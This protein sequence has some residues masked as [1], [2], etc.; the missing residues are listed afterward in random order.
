MLYFRFARIFENLVTGPKPNLWKAVR[1]AWYL[2]M[3]VIP[4]NLTLGGLPISPFET[5]NTFAKHI[6]EKIKLNVAKTRI[7]ANGVY[8]V[9]F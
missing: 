4:N 3:D 2:N 9:N 6:F 8:N 1:A 5:A 7:D